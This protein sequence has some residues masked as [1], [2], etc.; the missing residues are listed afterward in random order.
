MKFD[1]PVFKEGMQQTIRLGRK[2]VPDRIFSI[3]NVNG[4]KIGEGILFKKEYWL[5]KDLPDR[6]IRMS[7]DPNCR[8]REGLYTA[9]KRYYPGFTVD[10]VVTVV[11]FEVH[12][13]DV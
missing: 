8:T 12:W 13:V 3:E 2:E 9:L 10:S 5:F 6:I 7:H 11:W 4:K 1:K